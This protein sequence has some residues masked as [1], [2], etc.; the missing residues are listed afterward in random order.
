MLTEQHFKRWFYL[1]RHDLCVC[2]PNKCGGTAFYRAMFDVPEAVATRDVRSFAVQVALETGAGP[3]S[4]AEVVHYFSDRRKLLA[5]R[6]PVQRFASLWR[7]K[8][9]SAEPRQIIDMIRQH[10]LGDPHW[11][12]QYLQVVPGAE[13]I[14][15]ARLGGLLGYQSRENETTPRDDDAPMPADAIREHYAQDVLLWNGV[16]LS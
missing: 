14:D 2:V 15:C 3:F 9:R 13:L 8:Y 16:S 10:P 5:L 7:D 11:V 6:E 1:R 4:P 12:P